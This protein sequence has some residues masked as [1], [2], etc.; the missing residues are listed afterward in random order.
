MQAEYRQKL[1]AAY[2]TSEQIVRDAVIRGQTKEEEI[3]RQ[4]NAQAD[5]I[6]S[7]AAADIAQEKKKAVNDAKNEISGIVIAIAEKVVARELNHADQQ[8]LVDAF[9]SGLGDGV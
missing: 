4:A 3:L 7:K 6:R 5:A 1:D 2:A 8:D 9:I